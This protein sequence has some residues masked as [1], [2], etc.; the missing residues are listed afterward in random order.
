MMVVADRESAFSDVS[1]K[2]RDARASVM[3]L[4]LA[5]SVIEVVGP[6]RAALTARDYTDVVG[7]FYEGPAA[8][9]EHHRSGSPFEA[10]VVDRLHQHYA[11]VGSQIRGLQAVLMAELR[12]AMD[13]TRVADVALRPLES[14]LIQNP[15]A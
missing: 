14:Q 12:G 4:G 1:G 2:E 10:G 15:P 11:E 7:T 9:V 5:C 13:H 6:E 8:L 3:A